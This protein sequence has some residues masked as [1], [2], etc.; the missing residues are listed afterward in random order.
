MISNG[1]SRT[2]IESGVISRPHVALVSAPW[3]RNH[4]VSLVSLMA[5]LAYGALRERWRLHSTEIRIDIP[6]PVHI[7]LQD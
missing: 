5:S 7:K 1:A 6:F 4:N 3:D 2:A